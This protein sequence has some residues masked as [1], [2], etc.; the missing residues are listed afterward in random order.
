MDIVEEWTD[1]NSMM[2]ATK[3]ELQ[4]YIEHSLNTKVIKD[5]NLVA[6]WTNSPFPNLA[7][8]ARRILSIPA[9]S[10]SSERNFSAAV[11]EERRCSLNPNAV[12]CF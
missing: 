6:W 7:K 5:K 4:N 10:S 9:S 11:L 2:N 8:I 3:D 12:Y 1:D